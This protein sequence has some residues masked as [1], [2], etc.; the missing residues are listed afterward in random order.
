M[1]N[2][3][4]DG[5]PTNAMV[6]SSAKQSSGRINGTAPYHKTLYS[7]TPNANVPPHGAAS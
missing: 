3:A 7:S 5:I 1:G 4:G 6:M 2:S